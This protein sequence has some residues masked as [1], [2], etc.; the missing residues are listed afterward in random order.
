MDCIAQANAGQSQA[1]GKETA[2]THGPWI[3]R[4]T[5]QLPEPH[6]KRHHC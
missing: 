4:D 6:G 2:N 5:S 1:S 3:Q